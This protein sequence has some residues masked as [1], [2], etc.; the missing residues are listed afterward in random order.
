MTI[1]TTKQRDGTW[2]AST[3]YNGKPAMV[4]ACTTEERAIAALESLIAHL[5]KQKHEQR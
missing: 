4:C 1:T 3:L 5:E 2:T